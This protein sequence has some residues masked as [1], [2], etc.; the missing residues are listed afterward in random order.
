MKKIK[1]ALIIIHIVEFIVGLFCV[2]NTY[3]NLKYKIEMTDDE[4]IIQSCYG[5][6][7]SM[8]IL[9]QVVFVVSLISLFL[10]I[11]K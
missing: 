8:F 3:L 1:I 5:F 2:L 11:K 6:A 7:D 10:L 4:Y 9:L